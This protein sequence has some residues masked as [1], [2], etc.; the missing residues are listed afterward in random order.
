MGGVGCDS[1]VGPQPN[2][3]PIPG[4]GKWLTFKSPP[5]PVHE[6]AAAVVAGKLYLVGG[7]LGDGSAG[8]LNTL[9]E[10]DPD[11]NQWAKKTSFPGAGVDH[12]ECAV[13]DDRYLYA[14]GG[15][16][17]WPGPSVTA[18]YMYDTQ[19]GDWSAKASLP[20]PQGAMGVG[21]VDGKIYTMGGLSNSAAVNCVFEYDPVM[22]QWTDLTAVCPMPTARDH[23]IAETVDG[24]IHCIGGRAVDI[25]AFRNVHEVFDPAT[26]TWTTAAQMPTARGGFIATV[27]DGEILI[28]GGEG[29]NNAPGVFSENEAYD[30]MTDTW[31]TL[32]PMMVPKHAT[33]AGTIGNVVFVAAGSPSIGRTYTAQHEGFSFDF[34]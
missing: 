33:Q 12:M 17:E 4:G 9:Y 13:L 15:T 30:P 27:L 28:M 31:R 29:A 11:T 14:I 22:D 10:Y 16:L 34:E 25:F 23:F 32:S 26:Q 18:M 7:R 2:T 5:V 1:Q 20:E 6:P 3:D 8:A 24:K 21:V 19:T